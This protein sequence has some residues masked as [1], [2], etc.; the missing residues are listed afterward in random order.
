[1]TQFSTLDQL[2]RQHSRYLLV[3]AVAKRARQLTEQGADVERSTKAVTQA[4]DE[5][6]SG[7]ISMMDIRA[8]YG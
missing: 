1:M 3:V 7:S 8:R 2:V 4:L 6:A 5:I